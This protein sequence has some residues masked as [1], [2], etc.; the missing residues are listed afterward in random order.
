[1]CPLQVQENGNGSMREN[2]LVMASVTKMAAA[3]KQAEERIRLDIGDDISVEDEVIKPRKQPI[4]SL[5][6]TLHAKLLKAQQPNSSGFLQPICP[7]ALLMQCLLN[8]Q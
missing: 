4:M 6:S 3:A 7:W 8:L 1:M 5:I 2:G